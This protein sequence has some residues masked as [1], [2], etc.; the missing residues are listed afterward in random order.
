MKYTS[1]CD[2]SPLRECVCVECVWAEITLCIYNDTRYSLVYSIN[3]SSVCRYD[4][5][6]CI[7][8]D[9]TYS[10]VIWS[11]RNILQ[12]RLIFIYESVVLNCIKLHKLASHFLTRR[13]PRFLHRLRTSPDRNDEESTHFDIKERWASKSGPLS[14]PSFKCI[15]NN[16]R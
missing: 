7:H 9:F 16:I 11:F 5:Y 4:V 15:I 12:L 10:A 1:H 3:L 8:L 14:A 2:C 6:T 13:A